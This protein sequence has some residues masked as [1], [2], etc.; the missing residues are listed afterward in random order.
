MGQNALSR[1]LALRIGL[2]ARALPDTDAKSLLN[3]LGQCVD[4][5]MTE[6]KVAAIELDTLKNA[7]N[8]EFA[9]VDVDVLQQAL[10]ILKNVAPEKVLPNVQ[11]YQDGDMPG[12][13]RIVCA[14]DDAIHINGHFGACAW[15]MVYQVSA[16]EA[17]LIGI[18]TAEIPP[19]LVV[20]DKNVFRAEQ[21]QDCKVLYVAS[22]GGPAAAKIVRLGIHPMKL[23]EVE[24]IAE[25]ITQLQSVIAGT[26]PPWLAKAMGIEA[27]GRFRFEREAV[28]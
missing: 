8:G 23:A 26:P 7:N 9:K 18:R 10:N 21:I 28:G 6:S 3:I 15:F 11:A 5:P 19:G 25:V 13:V 24:S 1:E 12:S 14:T 4:A 2:A 27:S 16:D 22:V 17:R 20:D